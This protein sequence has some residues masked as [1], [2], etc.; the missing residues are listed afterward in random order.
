MI[1]CSQ[2]RKDEESLEKQPDEILI[3]DQSN[4]TIEKLNEIKE[5]GNILNYNKSR[6][7][8]FKILG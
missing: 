8:Y 4:H 5:K 6:G 3:T 1:K 7:I 2:N